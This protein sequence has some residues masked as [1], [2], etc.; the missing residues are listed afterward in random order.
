MTTRLF[1][2]A[3]LFLIF[4]AKFNF[5]FGQTNLFA[6]AFTVN[7]AA[8]SNY[9]IDQKV[10]YLR[11]LGEGGNIRS[12][13]EEEL[14]KEKIYL[15]ETERAGIDLTP[16]QILTA[17]TDFAENRNNSLNGFLNQL[18]RSGVNKESFFGYIEAQSAW[19]QFARAF[20]G[21]A[22]RDLPTPDVDEK[23]LLEYRTSTNL[24]NLL[25]IV[26]VIDD[27]NPDQAEQIAREIYRSIQT[28][29]DFSLTARNYSASSTRNEGGAV[30]WLNIDNISSTFRNVIN[31]TS[32]GRV[33]EPVR[34]DNLYYVFFVLGKRTESSSANVVS[35]DY[36]TLRV[37]GLGADQ[38]SNLQATVVN[39]DQNCEDF[40]EF[41]SQFNAENFA[42]QTVEKTNLGV[43]ADPLSGLDNNEVASV[44]LDSGSS[45]LV[46]LCKRNLVVDEEVRERILNNLRNRKLDDMSRNHYS[47]IRAAAIVER[48]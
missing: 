33:T 31:R 6:T 23:L 21:P 25:E 19:T 5:A 43:F 37:D 22:I 40:S 2:F 48:K 8:V 18:G 13:A 29:E 3:I 27:N 44:E 14:I 28:Q 7:G 15:Q 38:V 30:G 24:V 34:L 17:A 42:R 20:F 9:E 16:K 46:M 36:A 47:K 4:V 11:F 26:I 35:I 10:R 32:S 39:N 12:K 41:S 45:Y 1:T